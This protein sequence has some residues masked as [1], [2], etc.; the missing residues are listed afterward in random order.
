MSDTST[1]GAKPPA[2]ARRAKRL[3]RLQPGTS[4]ANRQAVVILEVLGGVR[5]PQ[6]AAKALGI[7]VPRYYQLEVRGLQ[8]LVAALAPRP[9]GKQASPES[10][11]ARLELALGRSQNECGRLRALVRAAQRSLG[12]K[13]TE[14]VD[15]QKPAKDRAGRR[16]RRPAVR[17]LKAARVLAEW[18]G[19]KEEES[20]QQ[21]DQGVDSGQDGAVGNGAPGSQERIAR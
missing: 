7:T 20:L 13:V 4:E 17:A 18:A 21:A 6:D 12:V 5:A 1:K 16:R 10:R 2:K 15:A 11:I 19:P 14:A 9:K 3:Q 8:G